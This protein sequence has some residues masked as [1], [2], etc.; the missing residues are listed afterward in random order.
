MSALQTNK[1]TQTSGSVIAEKIENSRKTKF[2][3]ESL[4]LYIVF[5]MV[6]V[7]MIVIWYLLK[8]SL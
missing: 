6:M 8:K 3:L 2:E 5:L 1:S 4:N 7:I